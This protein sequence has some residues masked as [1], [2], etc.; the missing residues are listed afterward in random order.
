MPGNKTSHKRTTVP[1]Q[2]VHFAA[3]C[4][5]LLLN[6]SW[7]MVWEQI[8]KKKEK[9]REEQKK[10]RGKKRRKGKEKK[11][12]YRN[13]IIARVFLKLRI[14]CQIKNLRSS[15]EYHTGLDES[16][17]FVSPTPSVLSSQL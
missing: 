6:G 10:K 15:Q 14:K 8:Y 17:P 16:C 4:C 7:S 13:K 1:E 12:T 5:W 11:G 2:E 3:E 9:K